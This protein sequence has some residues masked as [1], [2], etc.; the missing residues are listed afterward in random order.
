MEGFAGEKEY[1]V[2]AFNSSQEMLEFYNLNSTF[3][4]AG[5]TFGEELS[6][7]TLSFD[8]T[9]FHIPT[10]PKYALTGALYFQNELQQ[11]LSKYLG[12]TSHQIDFNLKKFPT[13]G[14]PG[15]L[16]RKQFFLQF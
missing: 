9:F 11:S 15:G 4:F 5:V 2:Q 7:F 13:P 10:E 6:N 3:V 8:D 14:K 16:S 12:E 1:R